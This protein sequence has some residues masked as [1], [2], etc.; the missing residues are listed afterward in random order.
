MLSYIQHLADSIIQLITNHPE[1]AQWVIF[2]LAFIESLAILG[3]IFPGTLLLTPVGIILGSGALPFEFTVMNIFIA[4]FL[5]DFLSYIIGYYF[6]KD[7]E[8]SQWI[9]SQQKIFDWFKHFV[10]KHGTLSLVIG[11]FAGPLRSSVPLF[12]GLLGM[13]PL[14]FVFGI[15]P[16]ICLWMIAYF[17]PGYLIGR[18]DVSQYLTTTLSV[19]LYKNIYILTSVLGLF[20]LSYIPIF[21]HGA[22]NKI[23][24]IVLRCTGLLWILIVCIIN[25]YLD[26]LHNTMLY[27][28]HQI[29]PDNIALCITYISDKMTVFP[30]LLVFIVLSMLR[31]QRFIL[32]Y[33]SYFCTIVLCS[34]LVP[35]IK[36]LTKIQRPIPTIYTEGYSFPSG[37]VTLITALGILT[38]LF[39]R[40]SRNKTIITLLW[41]MILT[42][43]A[44][45]RMSLASHW[46][47]DIVGG[48]LLGCIIF[49]L[50]L[51]VHL[52][53]RSDEH[54][55]LQQ[56]FLIILCILC[57]G[58][59]RFL[60]HAA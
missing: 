52:W 44:L 2:F 35:S 33:P 13:R 11:R 36:Y 40:T 34:L 60:G 51:A 53:S 41:C 8:S 37:H 12:A 56:G 48:I 26:P 32:P 24:S 29:I 39:A 15:I 25:G 1:S 5:G 47:G 10:Q 27:T 3:S 50:S 17:G 9:K 28:M 49:T 54:I 43:V 20:I 42:M 58:I 59:L 19:M 7:I 16:S 57:I 23:W 45:S 38:I 46:L 31:M 30:V 14:R 55:S 22:Y 6:H 18:P 4:A 21:I